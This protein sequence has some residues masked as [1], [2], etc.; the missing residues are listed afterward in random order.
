M[1]APKNLLPPKPGQVTAGPPARQAAR[2]AAEAKALRANL[3][4]RKAQARGSADVP[5]PT[6]KDD[7]PCR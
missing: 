3:L 6:E 4:R 7:S 2:A 1:Q 5:P